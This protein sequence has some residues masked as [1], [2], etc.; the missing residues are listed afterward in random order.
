MLVNKNMAGHEYTSA[1]LDK[2]AR[3]IRKRMEDY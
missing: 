2:T 3:R 1:F